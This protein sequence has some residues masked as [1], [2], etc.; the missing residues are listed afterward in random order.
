[1]KLLLF[2][3]EQADES[4]TPESVTLLT[5]SALLHPGNPLF[6]PDFAPDFIIDIMPAITVNRLG[7]SI[8]C[9]FASR[10][11]SVLSLIARVVPVIDG[12][13]VRHGNPTLTN[14]DN[15]VITGPTIPLDSI[16]EKLSL[17]CDGKEIIL[18]TQKCLFDQAIELLSNNIT[19]KIGDIIATSRLPIK[20]PAKIDS[21]VEITGC[22]NATTFLKFRMK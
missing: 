3:R 11:Y 13:E 19:L 7:K 5:D 6:I 2:D 10:Y 18:D 12:E 14:F 16:P 15:A 22:S 4:L 9:R 20:I 1:M 21:R 17:T 8:P